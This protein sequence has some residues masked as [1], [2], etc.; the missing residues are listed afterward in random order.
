MNALTMGDNYSPS[1]LQMS[2][3]S[4]AN[5]QLSEANRQLSEA[6]RQLSATNRRTFA[7]SACHC[8]KMA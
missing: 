7:S 8:R 2:C 6:N 5:R 3:R 4:E 1:K